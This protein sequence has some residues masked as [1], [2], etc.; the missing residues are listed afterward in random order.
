MM[1]SRIDAIVRACAILHNVLMQYDGLD[2]IGEFEEDYMELN[3]DDPI[4]ALD[5]DTGEL[6]SDTWLEQD[7]MSA[8]TRLS[9]SR[10]EQY[11]LGVVGRTSV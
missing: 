11:V 4:P 5:I 2:T 6:P 1:P 8:N 10:E 9:M 7:E 3:R